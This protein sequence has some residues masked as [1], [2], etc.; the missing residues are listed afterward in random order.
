MTSSSAF[1]LKIL[2]LMAEEFLFTEGFLAKLVRLSLLLIVALALMAVIGRDELELLFYSLDI[3][4]LNKR[5]G[6]CGLLLLSV[7][8]RSVTIKFC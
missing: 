4:I 1:W 5:F 6:L 2:R 8:I 3:L 7:L